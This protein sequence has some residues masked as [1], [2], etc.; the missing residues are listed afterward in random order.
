MA[1]NG[2]NQKLSEHKGWS[3]STVAL[4]QRRSLCKA[5]IAG[6]VLT[7]IASLALMCWRMSNKEQKRR[8]GEDN[9]QRVAVNRV[10]RKSSLPVGSPI[11]IN[12]KKPDATKDV[13][14]PELMDGNPLVRQKAL[15]RVVLWKHRGE[16]PV[17]TNRFESL[18]CDIMTAIPGERFL[19]LDIEDEFDDAFKESLS[20][21]I[22]VRPN[23]SENVKYMKQ[24]VIDAKEEVRKLVLQGNSAKDIIT[25]ARDELNKIADYRDKLQDAVNDF[26]INAYDI[27]E[28]LKFV[29]EANAILAEYGALPVDGPDDEDT[30]YELMINAKDEKLRELDEEDV[31]SNKE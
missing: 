2:S 16:L 28:T 17:F 3:A 22:V 5:V 25:Q 24:T 6:F 27:N 11:K 20:H 23:D 14:Q 18:V 19:D 21:Q 13:T 1:W 30:A 7:F 26:M 8:Q 10:S 15:G 4:P 29:E 31:K 12:K 9:L